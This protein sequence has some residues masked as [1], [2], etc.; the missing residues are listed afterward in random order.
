[1]SLSF[2]NAKTETR[3]A[4][5]AAT[6]AVDPRELNARGLAAAALQAKLL[7][8]DEEHEI[9]RLVS[10]ALDVL[11]KKLE[12]KMKFLSAVSE[13]SARGRAVAVEL[14]GQEARELEQLRRGKSPADARARELESAHATA[15]ERFR[16]LERSEREPHGPAVE[17]SP[18]V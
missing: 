18:A 1:M 6:K 12:I 5:A 8:Q 3:E 14:R 7:A 2:D 11:L 4:L 10:S 16:A 9:R 13:S 17:P 15:L